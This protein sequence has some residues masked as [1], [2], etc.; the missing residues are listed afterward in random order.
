M[1]NNIT[2]EQ[3]LSL[4]QQDKVIMAQRS[5]S[6]EPC[7]LQEALSTCQHGLVLVA[8]SL[9]AVVL[10]LQEVIFSLVQ[11]SLK[12]KQVLTEQLL[13]AVNYG[14][15]L[16]QQLLAQEASAQSLAVS[17]PTSS[18]QLSQEAHSFMAGA[19]QAQG[20][21]KSPFLKT[22]HEFIPKESTFSANE[23]QESNTTVPSLSQ[24]EAFTS[25]QYTVKQ[26]A[27]ASKQACSYIQY[28][29]MS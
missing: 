13:S 4:T 5:T 20:T 2:W 10:A 21:A 9:Q 1:G 29:N 17:Q 28:N 27:K 25:K 7:S 18:L 23:T 3:R 11:S 26:Q 14:H 22:A 6:Q 8:S 24:Q 16:R 12:T 15:T 19:Q